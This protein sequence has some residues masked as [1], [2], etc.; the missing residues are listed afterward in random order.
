MVECQ[1]EGSRRPVRLSAT[2]CL[3]KP[4][5]L[6]LTVRCALLTGSPITSLAV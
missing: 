6:Q 2:I 4:V 5:L 1:D 3:L